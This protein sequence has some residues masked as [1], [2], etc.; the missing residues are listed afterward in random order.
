MIPTETEL[1]HF[2]EVYHTRHFTRASVKFGIA[3]P[4]LTQSILRLEEKLNT[5]LFFRT[6]QGCVPTPSAEQLFEKVARMRELWSEISAQVQNVKEG[7]NGT[8]RL[9]CH[10]SVG[11]YSLPNFFRALSESAPGIQVKLHHDWS[12]NIAEKI[13]NYELDIGFV[14]NPVKHR[15][16]VLIRLGTDEVAFWKKKGSKPFPRIFADSNLFQVQSLLGKNNRKEFTDWP[17]VETGSLELIRSLVLSGA[18]VGVLPERV[19]L[20]EGAA[21]ERYNATLPVFKDEIFLVFRPEVLK[22][23]AGKALILAGKLALNS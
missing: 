6:K 7:L 17:I 15:D 12:R 4:S 2:S 9:G 21:L 22:T 13:L 16:L 20:A 5:N 23:A 14:V 3:Q 10:Q 19:A 11:A 1:T 18:G 8:F